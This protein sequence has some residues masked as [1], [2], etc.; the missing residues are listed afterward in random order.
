MRLRPDMKWFGNNNKLSR[1][2][3]L[4]WWEKIVSVRLNVY[5]MCISCEH[6]QSSIISIKEKYECSILKRKTYVIEN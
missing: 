1:Q 5:N 2:G 3:E 4:M 6:E